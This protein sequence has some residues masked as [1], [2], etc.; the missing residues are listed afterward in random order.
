MILF[1]YEL[2]H[3]G[4][5]SNLHQCTFN[6]EQIAH[7]VQKFPLLTL[8]KLIPAEGMLRMLVSIV[9]MQITSTLHLQSRS[10]HRRCSLKSSV[11]KNFANFTG[12]HHCWRLFL[13]NLL[14]KRPAPILKKRLLHGCFPVN[15][16]KFLRT[17]L[18]Q[19]TSGGCLYL[20]NYDSH[21]H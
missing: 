16:T 12:K 1:L 3:T 21:E 4:R 8:S 17:V 9:G 10:S 11:T 20:Q 19:N 7:I 6:F 2:E 13:I 5:F 15:I 14:A 18:L